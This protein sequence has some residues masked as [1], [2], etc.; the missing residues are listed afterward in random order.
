MWASD[1]RERFFPPNKRLNKL[2]EIKGWAPGSCGIGSFHHHLTDRFRE[3]LLKSFERFYF[4]LLL[5]LF[6]WLFFLSPHP[7]DKNQFILSVLPWA[8]KLITWWARLQSCWHSS[9]IFRSNHYHYHYKMVKCSGIILLFNVT[10]A[11]DINRWVDHYLLIYQQW[12]CTWINIT[13]NVPEFTRSLFSICMCN[14]DMSESII[15]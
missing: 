7:P 14:Q 4:L 9:S 6:F 5:F 12:Q 15:N 8:K 1:Q 3:A 10:G 11:T 2:N 13:V